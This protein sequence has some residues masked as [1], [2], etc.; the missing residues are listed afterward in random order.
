VAIYLA[1]D[2]SGM[3]RQDF[4]LYFGGVSGAIIAVIYKR[5]AEEIAQNRRFKNRLEKK[6]KQIK[7]LRCAHF[8][9]PKLSTNCSG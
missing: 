2:M 8:L 9:F 1:R 6:K 3:S 4:G 7:Y 5:I